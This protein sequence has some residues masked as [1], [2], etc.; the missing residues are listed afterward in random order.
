MPEVKDVVEVHGKTFEK[1]LDASEI[2]AKVSAIAESIAKDYADKN[3]IF[4]AVLNGAFMFASDLL[5]QLPFNCEI[6]FI[7]LASYSGT[8]STGQV[9]NLIG[10]NHPIKD[11][12][13]IIIEDI[14]D[15]GETA[16]HL[17]NELQK[18]NP[19]SI[20]M[21]T[22]LCKPDAMVQKVT[23]KYVGFEIPPDFVI[24]YGLDYDGL[25]RNLPHIYEL[26]KQ[27]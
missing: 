24:G 21:A 8:Q 1:K 9:K 23:P 22:F 5:K 20:S 18:A 4:I 2:N 3:P 13:I 10:L 16:V 6:A 11:R 15:T 12:H 25:G 19:A 27:D 7:K 17:M 14:V 26:I